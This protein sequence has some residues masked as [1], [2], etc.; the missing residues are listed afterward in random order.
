VQPAPGEA[1]PQDVLVAYQVNID[2]V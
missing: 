1:A 2:A